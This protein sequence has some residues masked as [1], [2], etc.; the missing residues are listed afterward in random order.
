[1]DLTSIAT[2]ETLPEAKMTREILKLAEDQEADELEAVLNKH[3]L[4]K[5]LPVSVWIT[6]FARNAR[7]L[8]QERKRGLLTTEELTNQRRA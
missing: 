2:A 5:T 3:S 8:P 6:R 1:M 4:W 7:G